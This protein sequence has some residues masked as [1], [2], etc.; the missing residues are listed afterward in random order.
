[1][2]YAKLSEFV[3]RR[4]TVKV[5]SSGKERKLASG[6]FDTIDLIEQ[7]ERFEHDGRSYTREEMEEMVRDSGK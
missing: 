6:D 5:F 7:A 3:R 1:M 2:D 4:G